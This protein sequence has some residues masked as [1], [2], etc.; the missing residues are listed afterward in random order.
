MATLRIFTVTY[1]RLNVFSIWYSRLNVYK[2]WY[3][4]LNVYNIWYSRL[5]VY[6]ISTNGAR[7]YREE[8]SNN[9][10]NI[11]YVLKDLQNQTHS[12]S[13]SRIL[14][15]CSGIFDSILHV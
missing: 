14:I 1:S 12:Q 15:L 2:I 4:R 9:K 10:S 8:N 7:L 11:N 13:R 3:S 5:N 6:R